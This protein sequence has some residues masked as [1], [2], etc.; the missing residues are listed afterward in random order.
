ME[1]T[2]K[3][4]RE[5]ETRELHAHFAAPEGIALSKVLLWSRRNHDM[6]DAV[7]VA[8]G[9]HKKRPF[10]WHLLINELNADWRLGYSL[11]VITEVLYGKE[12]AN[13]LPKNVKE[14]L[15]RNFTQN[16]IPGP[17]RGHIFAYD[18]GEGTG[19]EELWKK[20][21]T[22]LFVLKESSVKEVRDDI[23]RWHATPT[24][25]EPS[26]IVQASRKII[27]QDESFNWDKLINGLGDNW[28]LALY[29]A[30]ST[31]VLFGE[32]GSHLIPQKVRESLSERF[33][34]S[35]PQHE[36]GTQLFPYRTWHTK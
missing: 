8:Y 18:A 10:D 4:E 22:S 14:R 3:V 32:T 19:N 12:S 11:A 34:E 17:V 27:A 1:G 23:Y 25:T 30:L 36:L 28:R 33:L 29:S 15:H 2:V 13:V 6:V 5:G 26:S 7:Q 16:P 9:S 24:E 35:T 31:E 20:G 21:K